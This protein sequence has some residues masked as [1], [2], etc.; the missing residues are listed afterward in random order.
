MFRNARLLKGSIIILKD[1]VSKETLN[2]QAELRPI[3][4]LA[5]KHDNSAKFVN[6]KILYQGNLYGKENLKDLP[7]DAEQ[8]YCKKEHGVTIFSGELCPLSNLHPVKQIV[9]NVEY[10]SN[11]HWYQ[12]QKLVS[13]GHQD[14]AEKVKQADTPR[15]AMNLAKHL[16]PNKEWYLGEG[17]KLMEKGIRAKFSQQKMKE[18][19]MSTVGPIGE[20]TRHPQWGIG[21]AFYTAEATDRHKWQG[22]NMM[23][24][25]LTNLRDEL[26]AETN[27]R[28][29]T[30]P[31]TNGMVGN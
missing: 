2:R 7:F 18:Y 29:P 27:V 28:S 5:K 16:R 21:Q 12:S 20:A 22:S 10:L 30:R 24:E 17:K 23:G 9:D 6:E 11:E 3:L 8:A 1:D 19:L 13:L 26:R 14:K 15:E 31:P 25:I 4:S